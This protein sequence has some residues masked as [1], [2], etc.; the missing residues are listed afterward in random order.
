MLANRLPEI[1]RLAAPGDAHRR[2]S[3]VMV[4]RNLSH[5]VEYR[6]ERGRNI[7][8]DLQAARGERFRRAKSRQ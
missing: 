6:R 8:H 4:N 3:E 1:A 5:E 7:F 2:S